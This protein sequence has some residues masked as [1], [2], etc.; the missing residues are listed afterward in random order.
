MKSNVP[1]GMPVLSSFWAHMMGPIVLVHR[2]SEKRSKELGVSAK[3][4]RP[5]KGRSIQFGGPLPQSDRRHTTERLHLHWDISGS[6]HLAQHNRFDF[7][8]AIGLRRLR[9][10]AHRQAIGRGDS[11]ESTDGDAGVLSHVAFEQLT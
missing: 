2:W 1:M 11:I 8:P 4:E 9:I 10:S 7:F 5:R 3:D 6:R